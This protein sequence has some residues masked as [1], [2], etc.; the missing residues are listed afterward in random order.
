MSPVEKRSPLEMHSKDARVYKSM[1]QWRYEK[2]K[3][4]NIPEERHGREVQWIL[5]QRSLSVP[6]PEQGLRM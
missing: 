1:R 5:V 4:K 2:G 3:E 6:D